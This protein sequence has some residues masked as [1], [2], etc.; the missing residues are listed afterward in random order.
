[1]FF[2]LLDKSGSAEY[3]VFPKT[4]EKT[5]DVWEVGRLVTIVGKTSKDE[6]DNKVFVENVYIINKDNAAEIA[7]QLSYSAQQIGGG[8]SVKPVA[9]PKKKMVCTIVASQAQ[10]AAHTDTLRTIFRT[11]PG[12]AK[13]VLSVDGASIETETKIS[14]ES[15]VTDQIH[16][17]G[18]D[19]SVTE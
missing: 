8:H 17:L 11:N 16:A 18:F 15:E 13:V 1:M 12:E 4:Y 10:L 14:V 3:L 5:K 9:P 19:T 7:K 6:G 2:T